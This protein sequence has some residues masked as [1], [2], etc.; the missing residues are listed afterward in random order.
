MLLVGPLVLDIMR[1]IAPLVRLRVFV[2]ES[3]G[4]L[5]YR[6]STD[7]QTT[8]QPQA[9]KP[10]ATGRGAHMLV[11]TACVCSVCLRSLYTYALT[12]LSMLEMG[13]L[14][15]PSSHTFRYVD[16]A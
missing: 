5:R 3:L 13:G 9:L 16:K 10:Q 1:L 8:I 12:C 14:V 6:Q 2:P 4:E 7:G 11:Q 15:H